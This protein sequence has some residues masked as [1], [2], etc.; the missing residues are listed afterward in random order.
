MDFA[1]DICEKICAQGYWADFIDPCSGLPMITTDCNKVRT[2]YFGYFKVALVSDLYY[3]VLI[4]SP[5]PLLH[6]VY[7][8]VDGMEVLLN[9]KAHNAGFC[10]ILT[11]PQWGSAV[12]PATIFTYAPRHIVIGLLADHYPSAS[13]ASN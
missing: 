2:I 11:H 10:K 8:E 7:S 3:F 1:R 12:Y 4:N 9:Y 6:K 5:P 13:G